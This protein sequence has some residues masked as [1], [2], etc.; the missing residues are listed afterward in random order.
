M[1]LNV[2]MRCHDYVYGW[3]CVFTCMIM[4]NSFLFII[5]EIFFFPLQAFGILGTSWIQMILLK[6]SAW[7]TC[8][9][10]WLQAFGLNVPDSFLNVPNGTLGRPGG[11]AGFYYMFNKSS[12]NFNGPLCLISTFLNNKLIVRINRNSLFMYLTGL[13]LLLVLAVIT[14]QMVSYYQSH[15][16][17]T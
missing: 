15:R 11:R 5:F 2:R 17:N 10:S 1:D 4:L 3:S 13:T 6:P 7:S 12:Q 8:L 16:V 9:F 14:V